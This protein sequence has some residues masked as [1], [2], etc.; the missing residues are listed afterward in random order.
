MKYYFDI[1]DG[2]NFALDDIGFDLRDDVGARLQ[3]TIALIEMARDYLPTDGNRRNLLIQVRTD[4]GPRFDVSL[5]Y[6]LVYREARD[7][8]PLRAGRR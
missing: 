1:R 8:N 6:A 5:D 7:R 4:E 2:E 3:A